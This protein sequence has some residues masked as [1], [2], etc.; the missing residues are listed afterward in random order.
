MKDLLVRA[1]E[2]VYPLLDPDLSLKEA[3]TLHKKLS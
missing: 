2:N 1:K 3:K